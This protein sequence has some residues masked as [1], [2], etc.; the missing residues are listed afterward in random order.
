MPA[1]A[2]MVS[3]K[4]L[5]MVVTNA[6]VRQDNGSVVTGLARQIV[7]MVR[8]GYLN[9]KLANASV[10]SGYANQ[11]VWTFNVSLELFSGTKRHANVVN[12]WRMDGL[13]CRKSVMVK[14]VVLRTR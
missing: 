1:P 7:W 11:P 9:A 14:L 4:Q 10:V 13:V 8:Q 3:K 6:S 2:R 5:R 12:V